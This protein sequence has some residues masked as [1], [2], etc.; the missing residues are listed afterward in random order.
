MPP[1]WPALKLPLWPWARGALGAAP[2]E[3]LEVVPA[4]TATDDV[5][6]VDRVAYLLLYMSFA[7]L[8]GA[9]GTDVLHEGAGLLSF[10]S[11]SFFVVGV[12]T[13]VLGGEAY[14]LLYMSFVFFVVG[15]E[16]DALDDGADLSPLKSLAFSAG[17]VELD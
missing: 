13:D 5:S 4:A 15:V 8:F 17:G 12:E 14:L 10:K 7:F 3:L 16:A 11:L 9:V 6:T 2:A 1:H